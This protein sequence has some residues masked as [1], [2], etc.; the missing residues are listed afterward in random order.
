MEAGKN[1]LMTYLQNGIE[2]PADAAHDHTIFT[3]PLD[4]VH[5]CELDENKPLP[6]RTA[7]A[8]REMGWDKVVVPPNDLFDPR[9]EIDR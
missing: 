4:I 2:V 5:S 3:E 8:L 9:D 7:Q 6:W 1:K